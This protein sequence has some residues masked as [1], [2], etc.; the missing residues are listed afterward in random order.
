MARKKRVDSVHQRQ[1]KAIPR[2]ADGTRDERP[3]I[4]FTEML[5]LIAV[6]EERRMTLN[7]RAWKTSGEKVYYKGW[8]VHH[9]YWRG[10]TVRL[11]NPMNG[12]I[13]LVPQI[14]IYEING[15][16]VYL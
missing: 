9:D 16:K 6:A 12:Q 5:R 2:H 3:V 4:H 7:I 13:R 10:G 8:L 14:F 11:R 1:G 15:H